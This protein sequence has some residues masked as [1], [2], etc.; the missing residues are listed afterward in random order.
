MQP[1]GKV[2]LLCVLAFMSWPKPS[3]GQS[4]CDLT[5]AR[6]R[7]VQRVAIREAADLQLL[8]AVWQAAVH[9]DTL[10]S[11]VDTGARN[12]VLDSLHQSDSARVGW[13]IVA[14]ASDEIRTSESAAWYLINQYRMIDGAVGPL[15]DGGLAGRVS[16][17]RWSTLLTGASVPIDSAVVP[18]LKCLATQFEGAAEVLHAH[19]S[20]DLTWRWQDGI[21]AVLR[22]IGR[23][24]SGKRA[25]G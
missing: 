3:V 8:G 17:L 16:P 2:R 12:F 18:T 24:L 13:A 5:T 23:L 9:V 20:S 1:S 7:A 14:L 15:V 11:G 6:T 21:D 19:P 25:F 4:P 22:S 10:N